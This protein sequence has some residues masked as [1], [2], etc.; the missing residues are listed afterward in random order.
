MSQSYFYCSIHTSLLAFES[1][2]FVNEHRQ[3]TVD[4]AHSKFDR[5]IDPGGAYFTIVLDRPQLHAPLIKSLHR[6]CI[7]L[8]AKS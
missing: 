3:R 1:R 8:C 6:A 5:P 7:F 4:G 2:G